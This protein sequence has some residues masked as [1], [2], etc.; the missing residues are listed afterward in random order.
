LSGKESERFI[1]DVAG[2]GWKDKININS[3]RERKVLECNFDLIQVNQAKLMKY[4][5]RLLK[6]QNGRGHYAC[7]TVDAKITETEINVIEAIEEPVNTDN[8]EVNRKIAFHWV[9][10]ALAGAK[11]CAEILVSQEKITGCQ[12]EIKQIKGT[13][14]DTSE[15]DLFCAGALA[16]WQALRVDEEL[17]TF[18]FSDNKWK[19]QF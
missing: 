6:Q 9:E 19:I 11:K 8:C 15:E 17:P 3:R 7:V 14:V 1:S 4:E 13:V 18:N 10:A 12:V 16:T 5:F 2:N